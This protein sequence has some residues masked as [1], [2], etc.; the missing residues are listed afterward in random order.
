M[1]VAVTGG[2]GFIGRHVL[3]ELE[4]RDV[5]VTVAVRPGTQKLTNDLR[6]DNFA[7]LDIHAAVSSDYIKLGCPDV[8]IHLAWDGL[9][10]YNSLHHFE[11]ELPGQYRFLRCMIDAGLPTL[12]AVGT[13]F[14][15]G[16]QSGMLSETLEPAPTNPYGYAKDALRRQLVYLGK[17]KPFNMVWARLFYMYGPGQGNAS[18][19]TQINQAVF[20]RCKKFDMSGGEQLRDYL[21]VQTV[22]KYLVDIALVQKD[23]GV[24]NLC[25]G[26]PISIR[27][28]VE[29]WISANAWDIEL[30][31]G[32][33]PYPSYEPMAFWGDAGKLRSIIGAKDDARP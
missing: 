21:P 1:K 20:D 4:T 6:V 32:H 27:K 23:L 13:C 19:F 26:L 30:N 22:A 33:Y 2:T 8:L 25:S 18:L 16:M 11:H 28:L 12:T 31:L 10:N 3:A 24:V 7:Y 14:E 17:K 5:D 29:Q 15:Y 9:P